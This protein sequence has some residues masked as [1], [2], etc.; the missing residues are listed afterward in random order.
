MTEWVKITIEEYRKPKREIERLIRE[1]DALAADAGA[2]R[3][4]LERLITFTAEGVWIN[5]DGS[6]HSEWDFNAQGELQEARKA[7]VGDGRDHD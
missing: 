6:P 3:A 4:A 2:L 7:L 5:E 1:R